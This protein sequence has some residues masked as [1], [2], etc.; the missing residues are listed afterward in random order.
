MVVKSN[1]VKGIAA[2]CALQM[3]ANAAIVF[4]IREVLIA[5]FKHKVQPDMLYAFAAILFVLGALRVSSIL[6]HHKNT[7]HSPDV[8]P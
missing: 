3:G 5:L 4:V 8:R 2:C 7:E 1:G 6:V